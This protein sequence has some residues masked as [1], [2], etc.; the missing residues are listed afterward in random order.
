M[1]D[2]FKRSLSLLVNLNLS[3]YEYYI[4]H[5]TRLS[6]IWNLV[7]TWESWIKVHR[8]HNNKSG[9][10]GL[11]I[12]LFGNMY[13]FEFKSNNMFENSDLDFI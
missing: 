10:S 2:F 9:K 1:F 3:G 7:I 4:L 13:L 12:G 8:K 5:N 6:K 11:K